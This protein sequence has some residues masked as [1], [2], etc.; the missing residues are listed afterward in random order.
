MMKLIILD[1]DGVINYDSKAF[2][3][4]PDEWIPIPG[5]LEA[6]ARLKVAGWTVAVAT[7]QSGLARGLF[8]NRTLELIH[9]K[10]HAALAG[11]NTS[12]DY[13]ALCPH[14]PNDNCRCRK[15]KPG[16]YQEIA[17]Y[18][19]CELTGVPV[20]GDSKRDLEAAVAVNAAPILVLTGNGQKCLWNEV[21]PQDTI[22]YEDLKEAASDLQKL[23]QGV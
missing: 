20:I 23:P 7:N 11:F 18:F 1:R 2:V 16:M 22:V 6:I 15:P 17:A 4:S 9:N 14:G 5:S 8:C 10:M 21:L 12:I 3:K 19:N 13:I